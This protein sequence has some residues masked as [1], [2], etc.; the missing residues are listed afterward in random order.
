M[1]PAYILRSSKHVPTA[2]VY[3]LSCCSKFSVSTSSSVL[4]QA[5]ANF[6]G[7]GICFPNKLD[8]DQ[9]S[10][11]QH[12]ELLMVCSEQVIC[13][14]INKQ[15]NSWSHRSVASR[16]IE[17]KLETQGQAL[18]CTRL[19]Y[20]VHVLR[21]QRLQQCADARPGQSTNWAMMGLGH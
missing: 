2:L 9:C 6:Y 1:V 11:S 14:C 13:I 20:N 16:L 4:F 7:V 17:W 15:N 3:P 21:T 8:L 12:T 5:L 18:F 19:L 10:L